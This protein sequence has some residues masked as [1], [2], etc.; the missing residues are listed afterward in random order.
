[1]IKDTQQELDLAIIGSTPK[2]LKKTK[3][4]INV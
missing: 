3:I 2:L 4:N 1:M